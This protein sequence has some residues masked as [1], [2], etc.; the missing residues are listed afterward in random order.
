MT[1]HARFA[2]TTRSEEQYSAYMEGY[3][4]CW[5]AVENNMP[6]CIAGEVAGSIA[7]Q[8]K[9]LLAPVEFAREV[10]EEEGGRK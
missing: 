10:G 6:A 9:N 2:V 1:T 8:F 4:S 5:N 7:A 3:L